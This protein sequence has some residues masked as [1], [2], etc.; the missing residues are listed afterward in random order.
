MYHF[1]VS[2]PEVITGTPL[3]DQNTHFECANGEKCIKRA[4]MCDQF[5]DCEDGSDEEECKTSKLTRFL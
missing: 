2:P 4:W 5:N 1:S 3:C